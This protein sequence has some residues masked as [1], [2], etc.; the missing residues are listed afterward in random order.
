MLG[1]GDSRVGIE[2]KEFRIKSKG[3]WNSKSIMEFPMY[4]HASFQCK[5]THSMHC[6][7]PGG[8]ILSGQTLLHVCGLY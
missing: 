8:A 2:L 3:F 1:S 4:S 6:T 7:T 5:D